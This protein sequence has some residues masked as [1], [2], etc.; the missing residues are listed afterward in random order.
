MGTFADSMFNVLMSW[1]RALV[2]GIWALFSSENTTV[3]GFLGQNWMIVAGVMIAAGLIIDWLIWLVR[4]QPYHIWAQRMRRLLGLDRGSEEKEEPRLK[5]H[6]AVARGRAPLSAHP[7]TTPQP[8]DQ[9]QWLELD[10]EDEQ[11]AMERADEMPD[12]ALGAYPGMRY[13]AQAAQMSSTQRYSALT[14]EGPGAAEVERRRAE[15]DAWQQQMQDEARARARAERQAREQEEMR[16]RQEAEERMREEEAR[17]QAA[18]REAEAARIAE[19]AQRAQRAQEEYERELA[20]YERQ[21]AQY[22]RDMAEY[23]RQMAEYEAQLAQQEAASQDAGF[24]NE[25]DMEAAQE[26]APEQ[27]APRRRRA[28]GQTMRMSAVKAPS[29][30]DYVDGDAIDEL[31]LPPSWPDARK[32]EAAEKNKAAQR[33]KQAPKPQKKKAPAKENKLLSRMANMIEPAEDELVSIGALPPRVDMHEAYKPAKKP[34][35]T[36]K[37]R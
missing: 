21:K 13:G 19:E 30:S 29:Y 35:R 5:A 36:G 25:A 9:A 14:N 10:F 8:D 28:A 3:L 1:V 26:I 31:P 15:I 12:E 20:E 7:Q 11:L 16:R 6:A 18:L 4:W 33:K 37:G 2:S 22:E 17:R 27:P 23:E 32:T 34:A 24:G